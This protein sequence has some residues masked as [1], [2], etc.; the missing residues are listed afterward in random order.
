MGATP[1]RA[2][3]SIMAHVLMEG[4]MMTIPTQADPVPIQADVD[5]VMRIAGTRVALETLVGAFDA[6]ATAEEIAVRF[7]VLSLADIYAVIGFCLRHPA[8]VASYMAE[9]EHAAAAMREALGGKLS[10][11]EIRKRLA[12]RYAK[13]A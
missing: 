11:G 6:G 7:D 4:F 8:D 10:G 2:L 3:G 9:R 1:L 13:G 5:G 12:G